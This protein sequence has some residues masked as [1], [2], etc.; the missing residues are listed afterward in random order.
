[1]VKKRDVK[2][3]VSNKAVLIGI[4]LLLAVS[5]IGTLLVLTALDDIEYEVEIVGDDKSREPVVELET[6]EVAPSEGTATVTLTVVEPG[7]EP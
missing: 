6:I 1:L 3:D 7:E 2:K 4:V 5:L